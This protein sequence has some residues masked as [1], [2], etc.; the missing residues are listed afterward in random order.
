MANAAELQKQ[1]ADLMKVTT[2]KRELQ[3][4][5][6]AQMV[7]IKKAADEAAA[8]A[9]TNLANANALVAS[10]VAAPK[11]PKMGLPDKFNGTRGD[12][13]A[14]WV[15]QIGIYIFGHPDQFPDNRTK[16]VWSLSY[17]EGPALEWSGQF[18]DKLFRNKEV[19]YDED[20]GAAFT[21]MYLDTKRKTRAK[22]ALRKLKQTKTVADYTHQFNIHASHAGWEASTLISQYRQGLKSNV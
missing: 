18:H 5:A 6:E 12:K 3:Q 20:F 2:E 13:A 8:T 16:L 7:A 19:K 11:K 10:A 17:L 21:S 4:K 15:K 14:A 9:A 22:A 1:L